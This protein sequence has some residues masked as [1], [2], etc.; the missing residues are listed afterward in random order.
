[1]AFAKELGDL[2]LLVLE[3][4]FGS[5]LDMEQGFFKVTM[6]SKVKVAMKLPF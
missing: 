3:V 4:L 2:H 5:T 1:M 6:K